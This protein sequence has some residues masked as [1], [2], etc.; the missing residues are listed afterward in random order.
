MDIRKATIEDFD[1]VLEIKLES[2]DE[3]RRFNPALR[4]VKK[5]VNYY[6]EYLKNDLSS[7]WRAVFIA[8]I[9]GEIVGII[10]GK[11]YR[12]LKIAGYERRG[13]LSNLYVKKESRRKGVGRKLF[14]KAIDWLKSKGAKAITLE[15][16]NEN[17]DKV[18]FFHKFGFK[19]FTTKMV[20]RI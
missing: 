12:T 8:V 14:E 17:K 20:K 13:Y 11:T 5:M 9:K 15:I 3:E 6:K 4:P 18:D 16:H 2:K 7:E 10:V 19:D 1:K